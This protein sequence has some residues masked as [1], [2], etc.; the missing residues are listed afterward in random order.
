MSVLRKIVTRVTPASLAARRFG[1]SPRCEFA[2]WAPTNRSDFRP[3]P[4]VLRTAVSN[5]DGPAPFDRSL[6][7][8]SPGRT[9]KEFHQGWWASPTHQRVSPP[10]RQT[11]AAHQAPGWRPR[12]VPARYGS[13]PG[14]R[15]PHAPSANFCTYARFFH[16]D[17]PDQLRCRSRGCGSRAAWRCCL[18]GIDLRIRPPAIAHVDSHAIGTESTGRDTGWTRQEEVENRG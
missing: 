8:P 18:A 2:H 1:W 7:I 3:R 17:G 15:G 4:R 13:T 9:G 12:C 10:T 5:H 6:G 16:A 11:R 14:P